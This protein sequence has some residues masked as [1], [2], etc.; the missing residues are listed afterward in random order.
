[1]IAN[2]QPG[3]LSAE[4]SAA[5]LDW[6]RVSP[7]HVRE[8]LAVARIAHRLPAALGEPR[9]PLETF[10]AQELA[11]EGRVAPLE[12]IPATQYP[13]ITRR[14]LLRA[15]PIAA[16]LFAFAAGILWWAH[17]GQLL[18]IPKT[19][20][21]EHGEQI[22]RRLPDGSILRLDTESEAT[23]RYSAGERVV[24]LKSGQ[25]LFEVAHETGRQFRVRAG[26]AAVIA[27]GTQFNVYRRAAVEITVVQGQVAV[28]AGQLSTLRGTRSTPAQEQRVAAGYRVVVDD[29]G[30]STQPVPAD[31]NQT[32]G[33]MQHQLV[34]GRQPLGEVA[35]EFN[36]YGTIPVEIDDAELRLL[37]VSGMVD[38]SDTDSFVAFLE[39]LP[40]VKVD[41]TPKRI[42]VV[43]VAPAT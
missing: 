37:R 3:E 24:E 42:R 39:S 40:G 12:G 11:G 17:D 35:A 32:L 6:L 4:E 33:W 18:E 34:F 30:F 22:A 13:A 5:F 8:Y 36:R 43:K 15:W 26:N 21:T 10:L 16:S 9:V 7:V 29:A 20:R 38:A 1:L 28:F 2:Q 19:Y 23:V 27:V 31:L 41:R 14:V 25:A